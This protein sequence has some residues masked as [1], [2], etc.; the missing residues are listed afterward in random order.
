MFTLIVTRMKLQ[1]LLALQRED[2]S[3]SQQSWHETE[4]ETWT[5][6]V[7]CSPCVHPSGIQQRKLNLS[8][9]QHIINPCTWLYWKNLMNAR[10][11]KQYCKTIADSTYWI[12]N[13]FLSHMLRLLL[14]I[15]TICQVRTDLYLQVRAGFYTRW[16]KA[17]EI[18]QSNKV[19]ILPIWKSCK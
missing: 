14:I 2:W 18:N 3:G 16:G 4:K 5:E 15:N 11:Q 1:V 12:Y 7:I 17:G 8:Q 19:V 6:K 10:L 13:P 9:H